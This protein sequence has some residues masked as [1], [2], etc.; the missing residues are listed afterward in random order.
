MSTKGS[1]YYPLYHYLDNQEDQQLTLSFAQIEAMIERPLPKT[2]VKKRAWWSNRAQGS[3]A[4][5]WLQARFHVTAIDIDG[6]L[7]TFSRPKLVYNLEKIDGYV[8]W[9][10]ELVEGLRRH[11]GVTQ[12]ELAQQLGVRQQTVSEWE[13]G[14]YQPSRSTSRYLNMFAEQANFVY[15]VSDEA[16]AAV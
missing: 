9:N 14:L 5:A 16:D 15:Q 2:A 3:Q 1:K 13:R 8:Q 11:L 4:Q 10:G 7:V 6:Q 12:I